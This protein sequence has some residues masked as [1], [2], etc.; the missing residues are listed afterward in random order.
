MD[1]KVYFGSTVLEGPRILIHSL[2]LC[3]E[4]GLENLRPVCISESNIGFERPFCIKTNGSPI[5]PEKIPGPG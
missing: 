2:L 5:Y 3:N 1:F 4:N